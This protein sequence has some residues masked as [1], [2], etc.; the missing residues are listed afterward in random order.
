MT[1]RSSTRPTYY[2][3]L[4]YVIGKA[5]V[6]NL[7]LGGEK[8]PAEIDVLHDVIAAGVVV[9]AAMGNEHDEGN[10]TEYPAAIPE[11]CAVGATDELDK[12]AGFSNTGRHIDLMAPGVSILS[13][14]PTFRYDGDGEMEYRLVGRHVDGDTVT[15]PALRR[16]CWR[17]GRTSRRRRSSGN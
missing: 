3:A 7:S 5:Q 17:S 14:T 13:T 6:L 11:V 1:D 4:R 12:R 9:V 2:R 8:D 10:P 15:S 16:W